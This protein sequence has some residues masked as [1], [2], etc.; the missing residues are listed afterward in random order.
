MAVQYN[1]DNN[2]WST[3]IDMFKDK[4]PK[5]SN[6]AKKALDDIQKKLSEGFVLDNYDD[7]I[8]SNNLAD[9]SLISFLKV[10]QKRF[11][12]LSAIPQRH[13]QS[14]YHF[15]LFHKESQLCNQVP[16]RGIGKHGCHVGHKQ[17]NRDYGK[18][19]KIF[20]KIKRTVSS[21][22]HSYYLTVYF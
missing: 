17:G 4:I 9:E 15:C 14:R 5:A 3:W 11:S 21:N 22:R 10:Q 1:P 7:F 12:F 19:K 8:K 6:E 20:W 16:R 13:W 2:H 18:S